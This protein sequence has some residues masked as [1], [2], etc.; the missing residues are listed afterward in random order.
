LVLGYLIGAAPLQKRIP[1]GRFLEK[2]LQSKRTV[3]K[4]EKVTF[5]P[6]GGGWELYRRGRD[7]YPDFLNHHFKGLS[8]E[9]V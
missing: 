1:M 2:R 3:F 4:I 6:P 9:I 5:F 7:T 8:G